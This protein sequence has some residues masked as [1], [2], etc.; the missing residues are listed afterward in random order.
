[1]Y[2]GMWAG[3]LQTHNGEKDS[4]HIQKAWP[5]FIQFFL[6]IVQSPGIQNMFWNGALLLGMGISWNSIYLHSSSFPETASIDFEARNCGTYYSH[7]ENRFYD[8]WWRSR[9]HIA[10]EVCT[11]I[12]NVYPISSNHPNYYG[13]PYICACTYLHTYPHPGFEILPRNKFLSTHSHFHLFVVFS[14]AMISQKVFLWV[15]MRD[16]LKAEVNIPKCLRGYI[17]VHPI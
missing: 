2:V 3:C 12:T 13:L 8:E 6:A 10:C 5:L 4:V 9:C 1:M 16:L 15:S 14:F 11:T 17:Q 7:I